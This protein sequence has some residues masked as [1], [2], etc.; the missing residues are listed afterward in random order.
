MPKIGVADLA[1][2]KY[3]RLIVI[4][5]SHAI[6]NPSRSYFWVVKCECG[7]EKVMNACAFKSGKAKSCGCL[8]RE[9]VKYMGI[10]HGLSKEYKREYGS[11]Q[12][13]KQRCNNRNTKQYKDYGGRGIGYPKRWEN[14]E[15][16]VE[17]MGHCPKGKTL[18]RKK[19]NRNYSKENCVWAT[20]IEQ[21]NNRRT[22]VWITWKGETKTITQWARYLGLNDRSFRNRIKR[23]MP[24]ER[25]MTP[26][27]LIAA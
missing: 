18:E 12:S 15:V 5:F 2:K 6:R 26:Y 10:T 13:M 1:G 16:F 8:N 11:W 7:I 25:A 20:R 24:L 14:F 23:N 27:K 17:D 21:Q 4:R 3:H 22:N 9:L 19:N